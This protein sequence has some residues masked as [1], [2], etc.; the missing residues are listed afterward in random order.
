MNH[1]NDVFHH[2][3]RWF[4]RMSATPVY[5]VHFTSWKYLLIFLSDISLPECLFISCIFI[6][7][8]AII[9][10]RIYT[11][12][13]HHALPSHHSLLYPLTSPRS[14]TCLPAV[15]QGLALP[16]WW[17]LTGVPSGLSTLCSM[18]GADGDAWWWYGGDY[19]HLCNYYCSRRTLRPLRCAT[20]AP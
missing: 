17:L 18:C 9:M 20:K 14:S 6:P 16:W 19:L 12:A 5:R 10:G 8:N 13:S 4:P 11:P 3:I 2:K 7:G 15:H 1:K